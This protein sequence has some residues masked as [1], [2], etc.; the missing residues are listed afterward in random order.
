MYFG[1]MIVLPRADIG[2]LTVRIGV[3]ERPSNGN[4]SLGYRVYVQDV[5]TTKT[6]VIMVLISRYPGRRQN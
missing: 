6:V 1:M 5:A 3:A 2:L 4:P